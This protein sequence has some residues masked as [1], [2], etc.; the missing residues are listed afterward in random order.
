[1]KKLRISIIDLIHNGPSQSLYRRFMF[2]NYIGIMPQIVGVWCKDE[3]HE[4]HYSIYTGSQRI[5]DLA[6]DQ[7]DIVF[8]SSFTYTAQLAYALSSYYRNQGSV[9]V[10]GGPHARSYPDD[11]C[12]YFDFVLGLTD[13]ELIKSL[14]YDVQRNITRGIYLTSLTQPASI[15]GV[16]ERWEFIE[17]VH[18]QL[19]F[20]KIVPMIGSFGCPFEC[21]FCID[22]E[23]PY[24]ILD[25]IQIKEDLSFLIKNMKHPRVSWYDP[26]FGMNFKLIIEA[27]ESVVPSGSIDFIAECSLS[28]L[29]EENVK[30]LK[31]NGFKMI[32]PG[33]ESWF[34]YGKKSKTGDI[35]GLDKVNQVA[36]QV[37]MVQQYIPQ[38]Q[39]NFIIGLDNDAGEEPF[40]LTKRFIDLAPGAYPS[41]ALLSVFGQNTRSNYKYEVKDRIIPFPFHMMRSVHTLNVVPL[42]YSWK[43]LYIHFLDLLKYSFSLKA[44]Y[45]RFKASYGIAPRWITLLLS[46]TIGGIGKARFLSGMLDKLGKDLDFQR[47]IERETNKV[48][49]FMRNDVKR[50]LGTMWHWLPDKSLSYDPNVLSKQNV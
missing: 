38:V 21:D 29:K 24:Q 4:V 50:D 10:L 33:I 18:L 32:M 39:T 35:T 8:I 1:M 40:L 28:V 3:G 27:L 42:N 49:A 37:N 26:N 5:R 20:I 34:A 16:R 19:P 30:R 23:I 41:Y 17:K 6:Q 15:P 13:K 43:E 2:P 25:M 47:F 12:Q 46:L 14:L 36:E 31:K 22:S 44:M 7:A 9:T 11:A 48:P 45:R